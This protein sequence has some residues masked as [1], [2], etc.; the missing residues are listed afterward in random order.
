[1][2]W[3]RRQGSVSQLVEVQS[4]GQRLE[5]ISDQLSAPPWPDEDQ[6]PP[7]PDEDPLQLVPPVNEVGKGNPRNVDEGI[8]PSTWQ[9]EVD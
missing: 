1:M 4:A 7:W 5:G 2:G 3:V 8:S 6:V 9:L